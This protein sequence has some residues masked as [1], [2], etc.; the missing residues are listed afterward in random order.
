MATPT[1]SFHVIS[2]G[3]LVDKGRGFPKPWM[4][5]WYV[6]R[7]DIIDTYTSSTPGDDESDL[8][9]TEEGGHLLLEE[10]YGL[11]DTE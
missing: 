4:K 7:F 9:L 10:D 3:A 8:I 2:E 6:C 11:L 5:N 1:V